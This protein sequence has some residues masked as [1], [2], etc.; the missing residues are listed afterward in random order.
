MPGLFSRYRQTSR[1]FTLME[2]AIVMIVIG[3]V[4]GGVV[5]GQAVIRSSELRSVKSDVVSFS[6][7]IAKFEEQYGGLPG[8]LPNA[9]S[10][11]AGVANGDGNGRIENP[12]SLATPQNEQLLLWQ[13]LAQAR[14]IPGNYD[15]VTN[16]PQTG[17][18]PTKLAGRNTGFVASHDEGLGLV[19]ELTGFNG[20]VSGLSA[21]SPEDALS[22]DRQYDDGNPTTGSIRAT[23]GSDAAAN[24]CVNA[25]VYVAATKTP[26]CQLRFLA[27]GNSEDSTTVHNTPTCGAN[28]LG[29][30][31]TRSGAAN[32]PAPLQ[33]SNCCPVGFV[34]RKVETCQKDGTWKFSHDYCRPVNCGGGIYNDT[35]TVSCPAGFTGNQTYTCGA[36][37]VWVLSANTCNA[38]GACS[39]DGATQTIACPLGKTG[40][41]DKVC[42][43]GN[44]VNTGNC[45]TDITCPGGQTPGQTRTTGACPTN[46]T[47]TLTET[48]TSVGQW[49]TTGNTCQGATG[50]AP[51]GSTSTQPCPGGQSGTQTLTCMAGTPTSWAVTTSTC[52]SNTCD[53]QPTG[54]IRQSSLSCTVG[55]VGTVYDYCAASG[56]WTP[57][58]SYCVTPSVA[59]A[60]WVA[61]T[62]D[63][64]IATSMDGITWALQTSTATQSLNWI[65]HDGTRWLV[66]GREAIFSSPTGTT[67][68]AQAK[69][70]ANWAHITLYHK[71]SALW[72]YA[73]SLDQFYTSTN[74]TT[75]TASA[76]PVLS[77]E[78]IAAEHNGQ[79][80][81][82]SLSVATGTF[83]NNARS[84][85]WASWTAMP[86]IG[87]GNVE[88]VAHNRLAGSSGRWV[89]GA[90]NAV[91]TSTDGV[92]W[93]PATTPAIGAFRQI[94]SNRQPGSNALWVGVTDDMYMG[95]PVNAWVGGGE[96]LTSTDGSTWTSLGTIA[97]Q[98]LYSLAHNYQTGASSMWVAGGEN[99]YMMYSTNG[100]AWTPITSPFGAG[101]T[102]KA[103]ANIN[104]NYTAPDTY[105]VA[106]GANS[107]I[108]TTPNGV[109]DWVMATTPVTG[110]LK[111]IAYDGN[112]KWV[113]VGAAGKLLYS[114]NGTSWTLV[115][116]G[117]AQDV[118]SVAHNG[119]SG[120]A[121]KWV[122]VTNVDAFTSTDG[123][124]WTRY[125]AVFSTS[126]MYDV[127]YN[128][129]TGTWMAA[130][131]AGMLYTSTN[132]STWTGQNLGG[133]FSGVNGAIYSIAHNGQTGASSLWVVAGGDGK[134]ATSNTGTAG[135]TQRT[136]PSACATCEIHALTYGNGK[137]VAADA[138]G[139]IVTSTDGIT[140]TAVSTQSFGISSI[141]HNGLSGASSM[142]M[143]ADIS[144]YGSGKV[145]VSP[146]AVTWTPASP[147]IF[148]ATDF[149]SSVA[150]RK[151]PPDSTSWM[152]AGDGPKLSTGNLDASSWTL[153]STGFGGGTVH[154]VAYGNGMWVA[155][156]VNNQIRSS[157]DGI[158][159]TARAS[160]V[161]T[162]DDFEIVAH[163]GI[164]GPQSLF[165]AGDYYQLSTSVDGITWSPVVI[166]GWG[167]ATF[168]GMAHNHL[169]QGSGSLWVAVGQS[170]RIA[171]SPDG[172][173]WTMR[174]HGLGA[175]LSV[176]GVAHNGV[177]GAGG[178]WVIGGQNGKIASSPDG[179]TWTTRTSPNFGTDTILSAAYGNGKFMIGGVNSKINIST[180][181][182]TWT[183]KTEPFGAWGDDVR[184][185]AHNGV[186]GAG[187]RW[188]VVSDGGVIKYST[189]DGTTWTAATDPHGTSSIWSVASKVTYNASCGSVPTNCSVSGQAYTGTTSIAN[190]ATRLGNLSSGA[191]GYLKC[192]VYP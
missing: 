181:G 172:S 182:I 40:K 48:C 101:S 78:I 56:Q 112:G 162:P 20:A 122:A 100:T 31:R 167:S 174:T 154:A 94:V 110:E 50:C 95:A 126:G 137:F 164:S 72:Y 169:C 93:T 184:S 106:V 168:F 37:G 170:G 118:R 30:T 68:T 131:W 67:W 129:A 4:F 66:A 49:V 102:V 115:N 16:S 113:A 156:S 147:T 85:N 55:T 23:E 108:G 120:V 3:L 90:Y 11:F 6:D 152:A 188:V 98:K 141:T 88:T 76:S 123:V 127:Q 163:N 151:T 150:C 59:S 130:G 63:G 180:D 69:P 105:C 22:V 1:G 134:I 45:N 17:V 7:A 133:I 189:D 177:A 32:C 42:T 64:K 86:D 157:A 192:L 18:P 51:V 158:T 77:S 28:T 128:S 119:G 57:N 140:W 145:Y 41:I 46:M 149:I 35:K 25:G 165:L 191:W 54:A 190:S 21:I 2:L 27:S 12:N 143:I 99:G 111:D 83:G 34:G 14:L 146:D 142:F 47:G 166:P 38:A 114:T 74:S 107:K 138:D 135:W 109:T 24:A 125:A 104:L 53:G 96:V 61:V 161:A 70:N 13:H 58:Y 159:W 178:M 33:A 71:P 65:G 79:P 19:F 116:L 84:A 80:A 139:N 52:S 62:S 160:N 89:I 121:S 91:V 73:S 10:F 26:T 155:V 124:T 43:A 8:D 60:T 144:G 132:G 29:A 82:Y 15:G 136:N 185:I 103:I 173:S 179:I 75:W 87:A 187:S 97:P 183:A 175:G 186:N 92:T 9:S 153:Q 117:V 36:N 5:A 81:P 176:F 44:W 171:T 39:P 148:S